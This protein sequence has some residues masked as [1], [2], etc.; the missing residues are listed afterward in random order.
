MNE[1]CLHCG[2][3]SGSKIICDWC[4]RTV[5]SDKNLRR[6]YDRAWQKRIV[7]R[8]DHTC[9][10][11]GE[12]FGGSEA[13]MQLVCGD[14]IDTKKRYPDKRY[15]LNNGRTT[16]GAG[17]NDCHNLRGSGHLKPKEST[18]ASKQRLTQLSKKVP[19]KYCKEKW[20]SLMP[21]ANGKCVR[22]Q[23]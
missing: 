12:W 14:H 9:T 8:D 17:G 20:C 5:L 1:K 4:L 16:C 7:A 6:K 13:R 11:C 22:H 21:L 18:T 10:Y 3:D 23:R 19:K 2:R 15:D